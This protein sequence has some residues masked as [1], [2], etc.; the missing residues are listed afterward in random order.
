MF[1]KTKGGSKLTWIPEENVSTTSRLTRLV[2]R[3]E[4]LVVV[5]PTHAALCEFRA[6]LTCH[7]CQTVQC[8]RVGQEGGGGHHL[9]SSTQRKTLFRSPPLS[10]PR[11][12]KRCYINLGCRSEVPLV[13]EA[14]ISFFAVNDEKC[15]GHKSF[16]AS[17][18]NSAQ[19][20]SAGNTERDA[21]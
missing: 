14:H 16:S 18:Q 20:T 1:S 8:K 9:R 7:C 10:P 3:A 5:R 2:P 6:I 12:T 15:M 17:M 21:R 4:P 13:L 19:L 11:W